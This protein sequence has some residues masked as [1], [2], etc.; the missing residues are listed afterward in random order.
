MKYIIGTLIAFNLLLA[1]WVVLYVS[2]HQTP[3]VECNHEPKIIY[4]VESPE[5]F[6]KFENMEDVLLDTIQ[7]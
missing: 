7:K 6:N 3:V 1:R 4:V 5:H 2:F